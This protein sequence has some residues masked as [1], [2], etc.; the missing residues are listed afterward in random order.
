MALGTQET[1]TYDAP[2]LEACQD[3]RAQEFEVLE[4]CTAQ[5]YISGSDIC[6]QSTLTTYKTDVWMEPWNWRFLSN[7]LPRRSALLRILRLPLPQMGQR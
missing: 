2:T 4:V 7:F 5:K 3:L 6:S 1:S